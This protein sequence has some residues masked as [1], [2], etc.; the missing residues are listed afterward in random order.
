MI[1]TTTNIRNSRRVL[2]PSM[3]IC[4]EFWKDFIFNSENINDAVTQGVP[5]ETFISS[6]PIHRMNT[7]KNCLLQKGK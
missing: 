7:S 4:T 5:L 1:G 6:S 3:S 2:Y